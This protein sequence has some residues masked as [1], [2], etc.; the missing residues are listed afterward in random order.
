MANGLDVLRV[1]PSVAKLVQPARVVEVTVR[2]HR[3]HGSGAGQ[4]RDLGQERPQAVRGVD[5]KIAVTTADVPDVR[6]Q[7][8]IHEGLRQQRHASAGRLRAEP[9]IPNGQR[10]GGHEADATR[11]GAVTPACGLSRRHER[12]GFPR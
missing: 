5:Q 11:L 3:D 2:D 12:R 1:A 9:A 10:P 8:R 7:E 4:P 6:L